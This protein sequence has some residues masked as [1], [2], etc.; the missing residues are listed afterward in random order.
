MDSAYLLVI[1]PLTDDRTAI[2]PVRR[3]IRNTFEVAIYGYKAYALIDTCTIHGN[4]MSANVCFRHQIP[5]ED[6]DVKSLTIAIKGRRS[7]ITKKSTVELII[8]GNK[9]SGILYVPNL[10]E[11]DTILVRAFF[12]AG[13][14]IIDFR[15]Q[16]VSIQAVWKRRTYLDM[17]WKQGHAVSTAAGSIYQH[18]DN[19]INYR[20]VHTS[21]SD[22]DDEEAE[23]ANYQDGSAA[24]IQLCMYCLH[25]S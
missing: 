13:N 5:T 4:L 24:Q 10:R 15:K 18:D 20:S 2:I 17:L 21:Q 14:M 1:R 16:K 7:T 6:M 9:I 22:T 12:A 23:F 8:Q 11:W 3:K 19:V 25:V